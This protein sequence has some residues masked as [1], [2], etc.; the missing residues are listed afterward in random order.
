M[1]TLEPNDELDKELL[2]L[3]GKVEF[4]TDTGN[5]WF[6]R[7]DA[8]W[9]SSPTIQHRRY[10]AITYYN[11]KY[12]GFHSWREHFHPFP[13]F[14]KALL[15]PTNPQFICLLNKPGIPSA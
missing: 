14:K 9:E 6:L 8:V 11:Q 7:S 12:K 15:G 13:Y 4:S 3:F 2:T 1:N 10:V 5:R